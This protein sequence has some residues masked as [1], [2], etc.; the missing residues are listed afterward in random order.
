MKVL[1]LVLI[2]RH[3]NATL[4][5]EKSHF[6]FD[7][8]NQKRATGSKSNLLTSYEV[9][10]PLQEQS[11]MSEA[12]LRRSTRRVK[13]RPDYAV[14]DVVEVSRETW[15]FFCSRCDGRLVS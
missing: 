14:G 12:S 11:A 10:I 3:D 1:G 2:R 7:E 5:G 8:R 13:K 9:R 15:S 6:T 4:A